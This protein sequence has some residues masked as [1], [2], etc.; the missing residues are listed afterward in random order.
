MDAQTGF[1]PSMSRFHA[2]MTSEIVIGLITLSTDTLTEL[3]LRRM[4]PDH[5]INF[6]ATRIKHHE[7]GTIENLRRHVY[8]IAK[9]G[10][11]FDPPG[12]VNVFAYACT[13]GS[14]IISQEKLEEELHRTLPGSLLT[15][16]MTGA[17]RAFAELGVKRI[18]M[19]SPYSDHVAAVVIECLNNSDIF[20]SSSASFH[21][22]NDCE[23]MAISP[24]SIFEAGCSID[25]AE[26]DAL[27]IPC[28]GL[29]T[30]SII[31]RLEVHLGKPVITAHQ[32]M[33]WD[34]LRLAGYDK[35]IVG[36]GRL[37]TL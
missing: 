24:Q 8:E 22:E 2:A 30:S 1:P 17:L 14:A 23:L 15:S 19:L 4:L 13:S 20:V 27:F 28:T 37:L 7:P 6:S 5:N 31:D 3:E 9:A 32:A 35:P 25:G 26:A 11:L 18:S 36:H 29:R 34:A 33:L 12:A 21:A 10:E 16:P